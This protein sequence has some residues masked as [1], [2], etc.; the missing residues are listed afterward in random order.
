MTLRSTVAA[1][2][3]LATMALPAGAAAQSIN[4]APAIAAAAAESA[5]TA[6]PPPAFV[7]SDG[8]RI[9]AKVHK[10]SSLTMVPLLATQGF[11]GRS[12]YTTPTQTKR[13]WHNRV[14]WGIGGLFAVNTVTGTMNL[15]EARKDPN[16]RKLRIAHAVLM[17]AADAGFLATAATA[18]ETENGRLEGSRTAHRAIAFTSIGAAT[19]GYLLMLFGHK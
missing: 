12:L 9:R 11:L 2:G 10:I 6:A 5:Q 17:L 7:Y 3:V 4:F 16:G 14:A 1:I 15:I 18:P 19:A 13:D 8:Y